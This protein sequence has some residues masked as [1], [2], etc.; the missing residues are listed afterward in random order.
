MSHLSTA[1]MRSNVLHHNRQPIQEKKCKKYINAKSIPLPNYNPFFFSFVCTARHKS[2]PIYVVCQN[3][4]PHYQPPHKPCRSLYDIPSSLRLPRYASTWLT[5]FCSC[6]F[7]DCGLRWLRI[8]LTICT[9]SNAGQSS[10]T[11]THHSTTSPL[12]QL[13]LEESRYHSGIHLPA[14]PCLPLM[15]STQATPI[16]IHAAT[17]MGMSISSTPSLGPP[18]KLGLRALV[19]RGT[20]SVVVDVLV[21]NV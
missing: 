18:V 11:A 21:V 16:M 17:E 8:S 5:T 15:H 9:G 14:R 12:L 4:H 13:A 19:W 20:E 2:L 7:G 10:M 1:R 3:T 6:F